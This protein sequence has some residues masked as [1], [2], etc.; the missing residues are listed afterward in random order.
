M[1]NEP[2]EI[3]ASE[4]IFRLIEGVEG[5]DGQLVIA[6]IWQVDTRWPICPGV[7]EADPK[8]GEPMKD[9]QGNYVPKLE[10]F[11]VAQIHLIFG[12]PDNSMPPF[13]QVI[14]FPLGDTDEA[15]AKIVIKATVPYSRVAR[16]ESSLTRAEW[17]DQFAEMMAPDEDAPAEVVPS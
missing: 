6:A 3:D 8:T 17:D 11:V 1:A 14:G 15:K 16:A 7:V 5:P 13:Y 4:R 9:E 12:D 2:T 10:P